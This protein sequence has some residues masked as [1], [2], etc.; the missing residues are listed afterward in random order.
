MSSEKEALLQDKKKDDDTSFWLL[1]D[2]KWSWTET[3]ITLRDFC[4]WESTWNPLYYALGLLIAISLV[5]GLWV[6]RPFRQDGPVRADETSIER[7][8]RIQWIYMTDG[9][10]A[11]G[12]F[13]ELLQYAFKP[14]IPVPKSKTVCVV[15]SRSCHHSCRDIFLIF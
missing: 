1:E 5:S 3:K 9:P 14:Q 15:R 6:H 12:F 10:F 7:E 8:A 13:M 4:G 2:L 11:I